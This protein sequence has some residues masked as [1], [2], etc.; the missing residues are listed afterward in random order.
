VWTSPNHKAY[1]AVTVHF[2]HN[3]EP[4]CLLLDLV[5]VAKSHSGVN[6]A[7][8]FAKVLNDFGIAHKVSVDH[9]HEKMGLTVTSCTRFSVLHVIT[10]HRMIR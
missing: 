3:R 8:A 1:V 10:H 2:E 6:L 4:I 9:L 7:A 5:E